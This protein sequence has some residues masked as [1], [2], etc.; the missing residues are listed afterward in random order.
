MSRVLGQIVRVREACSCP[1]C[2]G[3]MDP[4]VARIGSVLSRRQMQVF[5]LLRKATGPMTTGQLAAALFE[6][7][8]GGGP[9]WADGVITTAIARMRKK[10]ARHGLPVKIWSPPTGGY[11]LEVAT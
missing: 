5:F 2:G 4:V 1:Y 8:E 10:I 11:L 7:E 9:G 3:S 6:G